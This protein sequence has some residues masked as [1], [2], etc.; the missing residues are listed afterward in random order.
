MTVAPI[1]AEALGSIT[2]RFEKFIM[3]AGIEL[4]IEHV[5]KIALLGKVRILRLVLG[6]QV[7][8]F[9]TFA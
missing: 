7:S 8:W 6:S 9:K 4:H 3:E 5:Q 1:V 2:T